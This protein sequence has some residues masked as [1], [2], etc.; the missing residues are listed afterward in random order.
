MRKIK[1]EPIEIWGEYDKG[2]AYNKSIDLY[3]NVKNCEN[4]YIG[5]QWEGLNAPDLAK[6]VLNVIHRVVSYFIS[7]I[8]SDD[9]GVS[10]TP[11]SQTKITIQTADGEGKEIAKED[12]DAKAIETE[13]ERVIENA[14]IKQ[15]SRDVVRYAAVDGDS[16]LYFYY[17]PE[18]KA[19]EGATGAIAAELIDVQSVIFG[20]PY[21]TEVQKQP[22]IIIA[23]PR[24]VSDVRDEAELYGVGSDEI[25]NIKADDGGEMYTYNNSAK[26][27]LCTVITKLWREGGT[28]HAIK[29]TKDVV[30]RKAWDTKYTRYP[31]A[32]FIWDKIKNSYHGMSAVLPAIPNQICVNQLVAMGVHHL[33][34]AT[35]PKILYDETKI[36]SW[37][38]KVGQSI[39]VIGNPNDAIASNFRGADMSPQVFQMVETMMQKTAEYMGANDAALGNIKPDNTSAIIATQKASAMPLEFQRL[40]FYRFTEDY[41]RVL[42]DMIRAD[43]GSRRVSIKLD[44][45]TFDSVFDFAT[46]DEANYNTRVDVGAAAYWGELTQMQTADNLLAKNI[47]PDAVTYL[48]SIPDKYIKNKGKIID[49]IKAREKA[50][51]AQMEQM[52]MAQAMQAMP[53]LPQNTQI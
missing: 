6:P 31:I 4:F 21:T 22:Y 49:E 8:I 26:E 13:I 24:L 23:S 51:A 36:K 9:I 45:A 41:I 15:L 1:T 5:K 7:M 19:G 11:W 30:I 38:N 14:N 48:E 27:G 44:G 17:D 37:T 29:C 43:Y 10:F 35:F 18:A 46:L 33:K 2:V 28:I 25:D 34:T 50:Q 47:I 42:I 12:L 16:Y 52:Q 39:G 32:S 20:N 53:N 40:E 3:D